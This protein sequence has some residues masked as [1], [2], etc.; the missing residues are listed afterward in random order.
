MPTTGCSRSCCCPPCGRCSA[1]ARAEP[2]V[3]HRPRRPPLPAGACC[4]RHRTTDG[5]G[6]IRSPAEDRRRRHRGGPMAGSGRGRMGL[7]SHGVRDRPLLRLP[8]ARRCRAGRVGAVRRCV[9]R[10]AAPARGERSDPAAHP[11]AGGDCRGLRRRTGSPRPRGLVRHRAIHHPTVGDWSRH[12]GRH[13]EA[14]YLD[15]E[16]AHSTS[17]PRRSSR[18]SASSRPGSAPARWGRAR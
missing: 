14:A 8:G 5:D 13:R 4:P 18:P 10:R 16:R 11:A 7:A 9:A 15:E 2:R 3:R 17:P 12:R 6:G 1:S